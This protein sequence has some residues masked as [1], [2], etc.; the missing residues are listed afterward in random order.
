MAVLLGIFVVLGLRTA[1]I[2]AGQMPNLRIVRYGIRDYI[3]EV[4][5]ANRSTAA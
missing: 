5:P 3:V 4:P 2:A 1:A